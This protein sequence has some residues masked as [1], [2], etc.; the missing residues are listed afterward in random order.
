MEKQE[1][2]QENSAPYV[3]SDD[4]LQWLRDYYEMDNPSGKPTDVIEAGYMDEN[5]KK[6]P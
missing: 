5:L 2:K 3:P 6:D 1:T 4:D